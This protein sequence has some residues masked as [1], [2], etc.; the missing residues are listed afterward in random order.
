[1][2]NIRI[3]TKVY[4]ESNI[5]TL[6][7][8]KQQTKRVPPL[9][10]LAQRFIYKVQAKLNHNAWSASTLPSICRACYSKVKMTVSHRMSCSLTVAPALYLKE[11][12]S[13][14]EYLSGFTK[15]KSHKK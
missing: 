3:V 13:I 4:R 8:Y 10:K 14:R 7:K 11:A 1:M 15:Y 5:A 6:E 9:Q 12:L 2:S